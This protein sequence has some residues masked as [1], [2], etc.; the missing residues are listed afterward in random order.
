MN[1]RQKN[2]KF[3]RNSFFPKNHKAMEKILSVYWFAI[4]IIVAGGIFAMVYA[5]YHHPYDVREI[6]ADIMV[7][8]ISDCLSWG[9]YLKED[10][11]DGKNFILNND[12][13]LEICNLNFDVEKKW[14]DELQYY[15]EIN[16]YKVDDLE[17]SFFNV[18]NGNKNLISSCA[19]QDEE[20]E[21]LAECV[22]KR[23][24]SVGKDGSQF[25]IKILS[26][27]RKSE[28]NVK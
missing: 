10:V 11:F 25:S 6:E 20:Y 17:N 21:K 12:N 13:F 27:V 14:E 28:K 26:I 5:F 24:Y 22:E 23:F 7:N 4:L 1:K 9:G 8:K 3:F 16:F 2:Q 18:F 15:A 19:I